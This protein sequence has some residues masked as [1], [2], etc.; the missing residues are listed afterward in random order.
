M[1]NYPFACS[2]ENRLCR[3]GLSPSLSRPHRHAW[4]RMA[5]LTLS[6]D[7]TLYGLSVINDASLIMHDK[8]FSVSKTS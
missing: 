5:R 3:L 1:E 2:F 6:L 7:G 8:I 4:S